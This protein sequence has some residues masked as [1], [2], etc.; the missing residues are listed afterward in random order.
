MTILFVN[1]HLFIPSKGGIERVTDDIVRGLSQ[2]NGFSFIY[3]GGFNLY[4]K[5]TDWNTW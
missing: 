5:Y 2:R 3:K 1:E 4:E